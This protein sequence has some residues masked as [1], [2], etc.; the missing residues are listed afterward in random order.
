MAPSFE[1]FEISE[2]FTLSLSK[3]YD[4][5]NYMIA[6]GIEMKDQIMLV[7]Y[8]SSLI[9]SEGVLEKLEHLVS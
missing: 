5:G 6:M 3:T 9:Y 2:T 4:S 1:G 7:P 8:G